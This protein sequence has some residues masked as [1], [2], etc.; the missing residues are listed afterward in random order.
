MMKNVLKELNPQ[1]CLTTTFIKTLHVPSTSTESIREEIRKYK[2][3]MS[4]GK[5]LFKFGDDVD[6]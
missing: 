6:I 3:N 4:D 5:L 1:G 2:K